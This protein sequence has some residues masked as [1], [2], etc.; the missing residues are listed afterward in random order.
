MNLECQM[1]YK[2]L[3]FQHN[4]DIIILTANTKEDNEVPNEWQG[5]VQTLKTFILGENRSIIDQI[6]LAT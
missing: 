2:D 4:M 6:Q 3:G 5:F 1:V